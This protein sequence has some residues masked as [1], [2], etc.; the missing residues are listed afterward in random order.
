M[1]S[2]IQLKGGNLPIGCP[3]TPTAAPMSNITCNF[4]ICSRNS[5]GANERL[6]PSLNRA[7]HGLRREPTKTFLSARPSINFVM[8]PGKRREQKGNRRSHSLIGFD[9]SF[10]RLAGWSDLQR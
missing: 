2:W 4:G 3:E 10:L 1:T 8:P 5:V 7:K 6:T 9:D